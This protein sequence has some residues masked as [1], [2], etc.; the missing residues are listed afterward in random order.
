[1]PS[2]KKLGGTQNGGVPKNLKRRVSYKNVFDFQSINSLN[3]NNINNNSNNI[4]MSL[5]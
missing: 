5:N 4:N 2:M 3:N 1:M